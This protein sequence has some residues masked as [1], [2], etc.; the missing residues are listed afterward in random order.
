MDQINMNVFKGM[1]KK[2]EENVG[3]VKNEIR[4]NVSKVFKSNDI[5]SPIEDVKDI[6]NNFNRMKINIQKSLYNPKI[7]NN[8]E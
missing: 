6:K 1:K 8:L 7:I 2:K 4:S 3:K 5:L